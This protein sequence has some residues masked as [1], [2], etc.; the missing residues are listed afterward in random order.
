[1]LSARHGGRLLP[2]RLRRGN[3]GHHAVGDLEV[4]A[5]ARAVVGAVF[6]LIDS[7]ALMGAHRGQ[8]CERPLAR[9]GH[10]NLLVRKDLAAGGATRRASTVSVAGLVI[11]F[12]T[13]GP[14]VL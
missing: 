9:L 1:M 12:C 14:P 4:A 13:I 3:V 10:D 2:E 7:A 5:V 11:A 8:A 6:D